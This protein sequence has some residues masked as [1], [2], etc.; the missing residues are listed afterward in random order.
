MNTERKQDE[1]LVK[2]KM[3]SFICQNL[4]SEKKKKSSQPV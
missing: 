2:R 3:T 4:I 1:G